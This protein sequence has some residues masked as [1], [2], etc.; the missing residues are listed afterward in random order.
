[1]AVDAKIPVAIDPKIPPAPWQAN[2]SSESS[3]RVLARQPATKLHTKP[4]AAPIIID[5]IGPTN[6]EAG[7][8]VARPQTAPIDMPTADGLPFLTQSVIIQL[9]APAAAARLVTSRALAAMPSAARAL[10]ALKPNQPNHNIAAPKIT[11]GILF[12]LLS[13]CELRSFRLPINMA[14]A[15]ADTPAVS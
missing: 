7:V 5:A 10:P 12:G 4:A 14:A 2:T 9:I 11:K 8:I 1:M 3:S 15:S 6:P 13:L